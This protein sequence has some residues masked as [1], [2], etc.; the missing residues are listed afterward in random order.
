MR[1][2]V[3]AVVEQFNS[4][5][6]VFGEDA[7]RRT[8]S[9]THLE[10]QLR[11]A[12]NGP[13][14]KEFNPHDFIEFYFSVFRMDPVH[15]IEQ[16]TASSLANANENARRK[17]VYAAVRRLSMQKKRKEQYAKHI[18]A[19]KIGRGE[20]SIK[21]RPSFK[22]GRL[23]LRQGLAEEQDA[24][25]SGDAASGLL[26]EELDDEQAPRALTRNVVKVPA[27]A[28]LAQKPEAPKKHK[29]TRRKRALVTSSEDS[30]ESE[31]AVIPGGDDV[32][33]ES[34]AREPDV[35]TGPRQDGEVLVCVGEIT[36]GIEDDVP[37]S[38]L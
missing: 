2:G 22:R 5:L 9:G 30:D 6:H 33:V 38:L 17:R 10:D 36:P 19:Q 7:Q 34:A 25:D 12:Y 8:L 37:G 14:V 3:E 15:T 27:R 28:S 24:S 20:L 18:R 26:E 11:C 35:V 23:R 13:S 21:V 29:K 1:N 4:V 32:T 31:D 16:V